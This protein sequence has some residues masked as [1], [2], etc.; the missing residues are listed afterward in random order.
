MVKVMFVCLGNICRSPMAEFLLKDYV[1][2]QG[3]A[4]QFLVASSGT[5]DEE[6]GNSVHRGTRQIL[7]SLN[8]DCSAKRAVQLA[9][10]DYNKYDYFVGMDAKNRRDMLAIFGGDPDGKISLLLDYTENPR[11]VADPWY[12]GNFEK[13]YKDIL[14]GIQDLYKYMQ[15]KL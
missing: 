5:S 2:K 10:S 6:E 11:D 7:N 12:T 4:E 9:K 15:Q 13:T 8:I 14:I 3:K 1:T